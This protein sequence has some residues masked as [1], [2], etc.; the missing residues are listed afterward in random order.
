MRRLWRP[1]SGHDGHERFY[2][3]SWNPSKRC[4]SDGAADPASLRAVGRRLTPWLAQHARDV[5]VVIVGAGM[6][7]T[8]AAYQ[9]SKQDPEMNGVVLEMGDA[10]AH[11]RSSSYGE[12]RMFRQMYSDPYFS[13]LQ[14]T[15][16]RM[17][18]ELEAE[19]GTKL[20]SENGLLFYGEPDTGETVEGS[21]P[22]AISMMQQRGISHDVLPNTAALYA[23]CDGMT[24]AEQAD[25]GVIEHEAGSVNS[26]LACEEM[27]RLAQESGRWQLELN[28]QVT[29]VWRDSDKAGSNGISG[30]E[31]ELYCIL[32]HD[33]QIY[34]ARKVVL[35]AGAWANDLL[36]HFDVQLDMEVWKVHWGHYKIQS[37]K[38]P[39]QWFFFGKEDALFYGFP[40]QGDHTPVGKVG[41]D[42]APARDRM[43]SMSH[44]DY[45]PDESPGGV[46]AQIDAF[47]S[48]RWGTL[49]GERQDMYT[50]PYAVTRDAMFVLDT[51]PGHP[52][53]S[54]F[55]AGNGRAFKFAPLLG[56]ALGCLVRGVPETEF[57]I[58]RMAVSRPGLM[59][60]LDTEAQPVEN[61]IVDAS[62]TSDSHVQPQEQQHHHHQH[63]GNGTVAKV[64]DEPPLTSAAFGRAH[65][66]Y[67]EVGEAIYSKLTLGC[68]D[69]VIKSMDLLESALRAM[70]GI[71]GEKELSLVSMVDFGSADGGPEMPMIQAIKA[72][73]PPTCELDVCFEDQPNNDFKSLF[74]LAA[75]LKPLPLGSTPLADIPGVYYTACG[76][77]FFEQCRPAASV[78][79][80][81]SYTAVH[82][83]SRV[84]CLLDDAV[85]HTTTNSVEA[86][87]A[88]RAQAEAD[89]RLFLAHR[90]KE[91]RPGGQMVI[92]TLAQDPAGHCLGFNGKSGF[93]CMYE[94]MNSCWSEMKQSGRISQHE[95]E[96]ATFPNYYRSTE[97]LSAPFLDGSV[98][99]KLKHLDW[100]YSECPYGRG[101]GSPAE[102]IGTIRTWS[103]SVFLSALSDERCA[104]EKAALVD[105]LYERYAQRIANDPSHHAMDYVHAYL[106]AEKV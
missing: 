64:C 40:K 23:T 55:T 14:T 18:R 92:A 86:K 56:H 105:E 29:D 37:E 53:V 20:L 79:L 104:E 28:C 6:A 35:C 77:G 47:V 42:F 63:L 87:R 82:W 4:S 70:V 67:G 75:G 34:R 8:A 10:V 103:N 16:L 102:L 78:D 38:Q 72:L 90:A 60:R 2:S 15:A 88:F 85:H 26:S 49:Y 100:R 69:V 97:E 11:E 58:S 50:S 48:E 81:T 80:C 32:T 84:P 44:F 95:Y 9:L 73:L 46:V 36:A 52:S 22:S 83:L 93:K 74:Y 98:G 17:W 89:W 41:V 91:L 25:M 39:R 43:R 99:L 54:L 1:G 30:D 57:D 76:R 106:L 27:M 19:S 51:L 71:G 24:Y 101:K 94:E 65:V 66:P 31:N 61:S 7:G 5:D 62:D 13:E 12:S 33:G 3:R 96:A 59:T 21:I 45:T 68:F